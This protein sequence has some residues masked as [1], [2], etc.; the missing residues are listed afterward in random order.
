LLA[1]F[2]SVFK[3]YVYFEPG[4]CM[5]QALCFEC[6]KPADA[7]HHVIPQ[8]RGGKRFVYLCAACH[9]MA[10]GIKADGGVYLPA[11]IREGL[12][13]ARRRGVKLGAPVKATDAI[14]AQAMALREQGMTYRNIAKQLSLSAGCVHAMLAD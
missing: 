1:G 6:D 7:T 13:R 9:A 10:H 4:E 11:L 12:A 5:V 3:M 2:L 8:S 14:K